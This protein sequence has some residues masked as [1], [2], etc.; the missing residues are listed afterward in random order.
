MDE[1]KVK[2]ND[3]EY[4]RSLKRCY[5]KRIIQLHQMI[6]ECVEK[7]EKDEILQNLKDDTALEEFRI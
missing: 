3:N 7:M 6:N 4:I 2:E 1:F 5:E